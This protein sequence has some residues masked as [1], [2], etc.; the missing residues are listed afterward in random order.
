VSR[1]S[2]RRVGRPL[3][4]VALSLAVAT[5]LLWFTH[6]SI[7]YALVPWSCRLGTDAPLHVATTAAVIA[8]AVCTAVGFKMAPVRSPGAL[9]ARLL[10]T[11]TQA[12]NH[13]RAVP[14]LVALVM[15]AYFG[16][17]VVMTG[18]VPLVVDRCA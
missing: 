6:L 18:L 17:V 3:A 16:F 2:H 15:A 13:D 1:S 5:P 4:M 12:A 11:E 9:R 8:L 14:S 7:L 10:G